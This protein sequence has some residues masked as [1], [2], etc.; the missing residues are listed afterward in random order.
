MKKN[1]PTK[2]TKEKTRKTK[3]FHLVIWV[4]TWAL[5]WG[6]YVNGYGYGYGCEYRIVT[7]YTWNSQNQHNVYMQPKCFRRAKK[8]TKNMKR[9]STAAAAAPVII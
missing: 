9:I 8:K 5:T 4:R 6:Q 7:S 3:N 1:I 2:T